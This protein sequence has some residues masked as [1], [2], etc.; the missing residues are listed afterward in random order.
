MFEHTFGGKLDFISRC[1]GDK[2]EGV[3][4]SAFSQRHRF[5]GTNICLHSIVWCGTLFERFFFSL[6]IIFRCHSITYDEQTF[7]TDK[8]AP[9][10][11]LT[12]MEIKYSDTCS[13]EV[14]MLRYLVVVGNREIGVTLIIKF[15]YGSTIFLWILCPFCIKKV[16]WNCIHCMQFYCT[17]VVR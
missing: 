11:T 17:V 6:T 1:D 3:G 5:I 10:H 4:K 13:V 16:Y 2:S 14:V 8:R 7:T 12:R 9:T 15:Y